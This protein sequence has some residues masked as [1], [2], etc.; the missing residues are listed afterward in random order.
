MEGQAEDKTGEERRAGSN[1]AARA[2]QKAHCLL[3]GH[4]N[5]YLKHE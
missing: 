1:S 5:I 4:K 2:Q 3:Q